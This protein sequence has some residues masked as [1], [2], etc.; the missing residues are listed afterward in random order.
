MRILS[1]EKLVDLF[2]Q[3]RQLSKEYQ[4]LNYSIENNICPYCGQPMH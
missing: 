4:D 3:H 2:K 1:Y